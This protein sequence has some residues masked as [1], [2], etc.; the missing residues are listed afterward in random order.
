M[1]LAGLL[2][3]GL[4]GTAAAQPGAQDPGPQ[5]YPDQ[6]PRPPP[7]QEPPYAEPSGPRQPIAG[8]A[9]TTFMSTTEKRWDVRID[10][11][12]VCTTPCSLYVEP[13]RFV[14][15]YTQDRHPQKLSVGYLPPG[16]HMVNAKP[17]AD[18]A[19][20]TG[21]TFTTLGGAALVTGITLTAIGCFVPDRRGICTAG[22]ITG[23][24]GAVVTAGSIGMIKRS[25]PKATLGPA[26]GQPY[27]SGQT[28]GLA[29][30]F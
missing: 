22:L 14:T 13:G 28:V 18:G 24:A 3:L 25:L 7:P 16:D 29:G 10:S 5:P 6:E 21:V 17:R 4:S 26:T 11:N 19:F 20:A 12:A 2:V 15:M 27:V 30:T 23:I 8:G 9:R 1:R